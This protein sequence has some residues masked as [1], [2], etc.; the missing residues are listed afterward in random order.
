V[1]GTTLIHVYFDIIDPT[2]FDGVDV[3]VTDVTLDSYTSYRYS[4]T[5]VLLGKI[6]KT[7]KDEIRHI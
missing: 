3:N 7:L 5:F 1:L 2:Y 4:L 6:S